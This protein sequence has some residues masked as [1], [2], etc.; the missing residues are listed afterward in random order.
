MQLPH[1][2]SILPYTCRVASPNAA[3]HR[4][5]GKAARPVAGLRGS[6]S[7]GGC[8]AELGRPGSQLGVL[9]SP[10]AGPPCGPHDIKPQQQ[11]GSTEGL[12]ALP[13]G[14]RQPDP[15]LELQAPVDEEG[16]GD[17]GDAELAAGSACSRFELPTDKDNDNCTVDDDGNDGD[18]N[19]LGA[20]AAATI[21]ACQRSG[22]C[23]GSARGAP[24]LP[25]ALHKY[26]R[27][28]PAEGADRPGGA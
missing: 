14:R 26:F 19:E 9:Q 4:A 11:Q 20:L 28:T 17:G 23:D 27:S 5:A 2:P 3:H 13:A 7:G 18:D 10:P 1:R 12:E 6:G 24:Q 8:T 22:C 15:S 16:S 21:A 25:A